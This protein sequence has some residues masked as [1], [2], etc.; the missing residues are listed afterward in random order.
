[1][2]QSC[3]AGGKKMGHE[4]RGYYFGKVSYVDYELQKG[5]LTCYIPIC[6][7]HLLG[8]KIKHAQAIVATI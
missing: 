7:G 3:F 8:N 4:K 5:T 6:P 2:V 1:V